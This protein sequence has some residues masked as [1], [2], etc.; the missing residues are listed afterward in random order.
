LEPSTVYHPQTDGQSEIANKAILQAARACKVKGNE[1][2]PKLLEIQLKLN[3]TDNTERQHSLF[4]SLPGFEAK[5]GPSSFPYPITPYTPAEER[6]LDTSRNLYSYKVKQGKQANKKQSVLPL[7]SAGQ[8]VLLSTENINL[9][10][11]SRK[12]KPRWVKPFHIQHIN[13][14][15]N[16]YTLDLLTDRHLSLTHNTFHISKIKVYVKNDL[17]NFPCRHMEQPG[18]VTEGK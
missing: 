11:T 3:S 5:L 4:F 9:L 13:R 15:Q 17:T 18:E 12:L 10:N 14:K 7:L 8:K 6:H 16:N 2:L 1:W